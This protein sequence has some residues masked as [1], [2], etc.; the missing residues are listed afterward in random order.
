MS[1]DSVDDA[2]RCSWCHGDDLYRDYHDREWGV[3]VH[4]AQALFERLVLEGMQ[5]GLAWITV[6]KKRAEMQRAFHQFDI[7]RL[8]SCGAVEL[9]DWLSNAGLIRHRGKLEAMITNAGLVQ[10][11]ADFSAF[12]WQFRPPEHRTHK[13]FKTVPSQTPESVAMSK[14]LKKKGYRFV[15]P[16]I[17]YAFMQSVGMV[18]DHVADC[19]RFAPCEEL[20][21][22][23]WS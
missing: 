21:R 5:A 17:C 7:D 11:E 20:R 19:W 13:T 12:I 23:A 14:A 15:G 2:Q 10:A 6:L 16:T 9:E 1:E 22:A 4:G 8:A 3:P 18:N